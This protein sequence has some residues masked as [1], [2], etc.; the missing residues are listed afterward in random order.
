MVPA[1]ARSGPPTARRYRC[2]RARTISLDRPPPPGPSHRSPRGRPGRR[3]SPVAPLHLDPCLVAGAIFSRRALARH[4]PA[5]EAAIFAA[6]NA[7]SAFMIPP[8]VS[9][10][11]DG[12][13]CVGISLSP[14]I[15]VEGRGARSTKGGVSRVQH[16]AL[17]RNVTTRPTVRHSSR[18]RTPIPQPFSL[19]SAHLRRACRRGGLHGIADGG[20]LL[21]FLRLLAVIAAR[22]FTP[23]PSSPSR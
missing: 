13:D 11:R 20:L 19:V 12:A 5:V 14:F 7:T 21:G 10:R 16:A 1:R 9:S 4:G 15:S 2:R 18:S 23:P 3:R 22:P 8:A 17:L 6:L